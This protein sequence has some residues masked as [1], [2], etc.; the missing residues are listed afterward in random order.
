MFKNKNDNR[1]D[2]FEI[3]WA[4]L[5]AMVEP[6]FAERSV[7][8]HSDYLTN[9][10]IVTS[11]AVNITE[12]EVLTAQGDLIAYDYLVV[13]TGHMESFSRTRIEK[14]SQ[15]QEE[16]KKIKSANS[17]LIIG[18]GPTGVELA[19][20]IVVDFPDKKVTLVHRGP[21]L[22]EFIGSK[23][24]NKA[25][26]WLTSKKVEVIFQQSVDLNSVSDGIYH[27]SGGETITA[28]CHFL[29]TGKPLSSAWLKETVLKN[30]LDMHGRLKV[31]EHL[32]VRGHENIF[33]I[34]DITDISVWL[35]FILT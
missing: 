34:G 15:Y 23:A 9:G 16:F 31:D 28:D 1:K 2:Y 32:R 25:L 3:S 4:S 24:S 29:C 7:I 19:G 20:E 13:A 21:R 8:N 6:S 14:L 33:A 26:N 30:R 27:T 18:G 35:R 12:S 5:R 10:H 22:L 11:T 17:I